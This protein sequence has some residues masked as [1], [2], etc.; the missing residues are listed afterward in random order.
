MVMGLIVMAV[1]V[2]IPVTVS[3][4]LHVFSVKLKQLFALI[5]RYSVCPALV[6]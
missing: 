1:D 3:R 2:G 6:I 5:L 4:S